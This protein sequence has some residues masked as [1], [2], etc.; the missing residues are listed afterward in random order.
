MTKI[1]VIDD[2]ADILHV[3][4]EWLTMHDYE[5]LLAQS[6]PHALQ[7][8]QEH[9]P[10]LIL[11]D[12]NMPGMDGLETARQLRL[13]PATANIPILL[14]AGTDLTQREDE[15][16]RITGNAI[17]RKP[18]NLEE[19]GRRIRVLLT[20]AK[21]TGES[22]HSLREA[23]H[24]GLT[25]LQ[26]NLIWFLRVDHGKS[27]LVH[28]SIATTAGQS[29]TTHFLEIATGERPGIAFALS[30][31]ATD[32]VSRAALQGKASFNVSLGS[33]QDDSLHAFR[34]ACDSLD[35]AFLA[36]TPVRLDNVIQGVLIVASSEPRDVETTHGRQLMDVVVN[37]VTA[38]LENQKLTNSLRQRQTAPGE[39]S[40]PLTDLL[41]A[42]SDGLVIYDE[43]L[44]IT[45]A[46]ERIAFLAGR[47]QESLLGMRVDE[48]C[49][50]DHQKRIKA[51]IQDPQ[52]G[53]EIALEI[54]LLRPDNELYPVLVRHIESETL[55][56]TSHALAFADLQ[57]R[58]LNERILRKQSHHLTALNRASRAINST[59]TLD[60]ALRI[61]LVEASFALDASVACV[62][63]RPSDSEQL[64][65]HS[66]VGEH[67]EQLRGIRIP[68]E[69]SVAGFVTR[70]ELAL[71]IDDIQEEK[72]FLPEINPDT[73]VET[74]S[75]AAVPL[76]V[77]DEAVGVVEVIS[78][79][80]GKFIFD[81]LETLQGLARAAA[82]SIENASLFG[83]T[84]RQVRELTLLLQASEA[85]SSTLT[86]E[87]VLET[88]SQQLIQALSVTW[89][90]IS[91]WSSEED[92][93]VKLA[94][95]AEVLW[96]EDRGQTISLEDYSL[97]AEALTSGEPFITGIDMRDVESSRRQ[98]LLDA[99]YWSVLTLP[100]LLH[101]RVYGVVELYH[102]SSR[103]I[104]SEADVD[105]CQAVLT[106]WGN[107][108]EQDASMDRMSFWQPLSAKLLDVS[109]TAWCK[110]LSYDQQTN[111]LAI[112]SEMGR[113]VWPI[114]QGDS[115]VLDAASL[116][117]V[118]LMERTAIAIQID[119]G[120]LSPGD[121]RTIPYLDSG[122]MLMAPL[123]AHGEAIGLVQLID[124]DSRRVFAEKDL[125][126]AQAIANVVGSALE[127]G[128]LY[129]ALARRAAQLEAAY[130]DL[131]D[132]DRT[133][134]EMIQNISHEL[135]TPLGPVIGYT[136][137]LLAGDLGDL[138]EE[139]QH[140]L[141]TMSVQSRLLNRM[142]NDILSIQH[143][144][145][146]YF[147][148]KEVDLGQLA[149]T[150]LESMALEARKREIKLM[151]DIPD[152]LPT[153]NIDEERILQV[154]EGLLANAIKFST[155]ASTV[156]LSIHD[157]EHFLEVDVR[158]E[159]IGIPEE[160]FPKIWR[161]FYQVDG[162]TTRSFNGLGLGLT[163]VKQVVEKHNGQVSVNSEPGKGS[164]FSF[165]LPKQG[166]IDR[167]RGVEAPE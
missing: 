23:V 64:F 166:M 28:G 92:T 155:R 21:P 45:W 125:S 109:G 130:N 120:Q 85:A 147:E 31:S 40:A 67:T 79:E 44:Q 164:V 30:A 60:E 73:G 152:G 16:V 91:S 89:C 39:G 103:L 53:D 56:P 54:R 41:D 139:Q 107:S 118:A 9:I 50:P 15:A 90:I 43:N 113:A 59:L 37:Y 117:R 133:T 119:E 150:A 2:E 71:V 161:R 11:L 74:R 121:Q 136:D 104:F 75:I 126:L 12:S 122:S 160:E 127:N 138:N 65:L 163:I 72:R 108:V 49:D 8:V 36:V 99:G 69:K 29:V 7:I 4:S 51:L 32:V 102:A 124:M 145:D 159:G 148:L 63:L 52:Q 86:I 141:E 33:L 153:V 20:S 96:A 22:E 137:M 19:L 101:G 142:V 135:R 58:K 61:I 98:S 88:V 1:L 34:T 26:A 27:A 154:F 132:A 55:A 66:A 140:V 143:I 5:A 106:G 57:E 151:T 165:T 17:L 105:R 14:I 134:D 68:L 42:V 78:G 80:P 97:T 47:S 144:V 13:L 70:E 123:I 82:I 10:D 128:R 94:E 35:L 115:S 24:A 76:L 6:G 46:N 114:G 3:M 110:I 25:I 84:Q 62:I 100:L 149:R 83:E 18:V 156:T 112:V 157:L 93:L 129:S 111:S 87:T 116:C 167:I 81:D 131:R 48:L 158:D 95:V 162:S 77:Q 38:T 146:E